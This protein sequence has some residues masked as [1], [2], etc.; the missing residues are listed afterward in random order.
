[1]AV[2][3]RYSRHIAWSPDD[4]CFIA[5]V[6]ELSQVSA[7]GDTQVEAL[8]ELEVALEGVF[9]IFEEEGLALPAPAAKKRPNLPSGKFQARLPRQLH[10]RLAD[11]ARDE[12][13][14]INTLLISM[15]SEAVGERDTL[16]RVREALEQ[17][18]AGPR[19]SSGAHESWRDPANGARSTAPIADDS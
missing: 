9:E 2:T 19:E 15:I 18:L 5:T 16:V 12:G 7:F 4:A 10:K 11:A 8:A 6:A 3:D 1:M 17:G 13:V 14:S